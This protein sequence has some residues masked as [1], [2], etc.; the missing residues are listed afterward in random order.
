MAR[1]TRGYEWGSGFAMGLVVGCLLTVL[2]VQMSG[3]CQ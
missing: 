3:V 2:Y 1:R